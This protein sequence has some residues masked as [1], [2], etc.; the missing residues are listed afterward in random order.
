MNVIITGAG[1]MLGRALVSNI[2]RCEASRVYALT[3][4]IERTRSMLPDDIDVAIVANSDASWLFR[5]ICPDALI[6]CAFSRGNDGASLRY[7]LDF[8]G[9]V[10]SL[11]S[12][13][14]ATVNVSSQSVY[15]AARALPAKEAEA[16][17][18]PASSYAIAKFSTEVMLSRFCR[19]RLKT[20][21]RLASLLSPSFGDRFVNKMVRAGRE[22]GV[23]KLAGP[24]DVFGFL[25]V[26][27]AADGIASMLRCL[28]MQGWETVY[29][30][31]PKEMGF[32]LETIG[33]CV[34]N[35]LN[36]KGHPCRLDDGV[37]GGSEKSS[38]L[39]SGAF[40]RDFGWSSAFGLAEIIDSIID[41]QDLA[42]RND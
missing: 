6:H 35:R 12:E 40:Q 17:I 31:G 24:N 13:K 38:A 1:G 32:S 16:P 7:A 3:T 28:S 29:N 33:E 21:L 4:S 34:V 30:L 41:F 22:D 10:F 26:R 19:S 15:C 36:L 5:D 25:S 20:N 18:A 23:V 14:C 8:T 37:S 11:V 39:D 9:E 42:V 2:A 27:D